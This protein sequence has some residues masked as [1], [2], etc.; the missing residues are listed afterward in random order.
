MRKELQTEK[1][2]LMLY[3]IVGVVIIVISTGVA[4]IF[5]RELIL[6]MGPEGLAILAGIEFTILMCA[7][8]FLV[9][10][11]IRTLDKISYLKQWIEENEKDDQGGMR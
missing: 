3:A 11:I 4:E 6:S 2:R 9:E 5:D 8:M 10:M 7:F 1:T